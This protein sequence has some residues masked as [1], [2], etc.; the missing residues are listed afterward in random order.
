MVILC[1]SLIFFSLFFAGTDHG[2]RSNFAF[3]C[4]LGILFF[5]HFYVV[6]NRISWNRLTVTQMVIISFLF[7]LFWNSAFFNANTIKNYN[8]LVWLGLISFNYSFIYWLSCF[9]RQNSQVNSINSI[10]RSIKKYLIPFVVLLLFVLSSLDIFTQSPRVDSYEYVN[11]IKSASEWNF[12]LL[13]FQNFRLCW[14]FSFG[15]TFFALIGQFLLP[16]GYI[17]IRLINLLMGC[18]TIYAFWKI[19]KKLFSNRSLIIEITIML[20]FALHPGFHGILAEVDLDYA[21]FCFFVWL[22]AAQLYNYKILKIFCFTLLVFSKEPGVI[23]AAA[24]AG[25]EVIYDLFV[26]DEQGILLK[27]KKV[28]SGVSGIFLIIGFLWLLIAYLLKDSVWTGGGHESSSLIITAQEKGNSFGLDPQYIIFKL[29][30][31][32]LMNFNWIIL[33]LVI[34]STLLL[35]RFKKRHIIITKFFLINAISFMSFLGFNIGYITYVHYR[36]IRLNVYFLAII[37]AFCL[38]SLS[39]IRK[40]IS[41]LGIFIACC[42][43]IQ[44]FY[45]IDPVTF[46]LFRN[47]NIGNGRIITTRKYTRDSQSNFI[48][49]GE[50]AYNYTFLDSS[51]NNKQS[52]GLEAVLE[53]TLSQV[54]N[55]S[56]SLIIFPDIYKEQTLRSMFGRLDK[57]TY[58][59]NETTNEISDYPGDILLNVI[60]STDWEKDMWDQYDNI[61]YI[62]FPYNESYNDDLFLQQFSVSDSE[63]ISYLSWSIQL[64]KLNEKYSNGQ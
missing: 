15:Y 24:F 41:I 53:K 6:Y 9:I 49:G 19:Y 61:Y 27:L 13:E 32:F 16:E 17:G 25:A 10:K 18:V 31:I 60:V 12:T 39:K 28:F 62:V 58:R 7:S 38:H 2:L 11:S 57:N 43:V 51:Y 34:V 56:S 4:S 46:A 26:S 23:Y 59:W 45:M 1:F 55:I 63:E 33:L 50:R 35:M 22:A 48:L 37:L 29:Q 5:G 20:V 47:V 40:R 64:L 42:I 44:N 36:Y 52:Y 30:E 14:H 3:A 8:F 21:L 54:E